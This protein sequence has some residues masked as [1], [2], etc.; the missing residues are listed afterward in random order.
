[1]SGPIPK[2]DPLWLWMR[3]AEKKRHAGAYLGYVGY[4]AL[5]AAT[6]QEVSA[7]KA[8]E[9]I[10]A[11]RDTVR[12]L[13]GQF[14]TLG[15]VYRSGWVRESTNGFDQPLYRIRVEDEQ[16]VPARLT[17]AGGPMP[18]ADHEH[19]PQER[20]RSFAS[21]VEALKN[22]CLSR[23]ELA[24]KTGLSAARI[25]KVLSYMASP[26]VKLIYVADWRWRGGKPG[27]PPSKLWEFGLDKRNAFRPKPIGRGRRDCKR[28][29][30]TLGS[31]PTWERT[32]AMLR[33]TAGFH[34][35]FSASVTKPRTKKEIPCP[36]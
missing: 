16:D 13:L 26:G 22:D 25:T 29:V 11:H 4:A 5:L 30:E 28:A 7:T 9:I 8:A 1:M 17:S 21:L 18:H 3:G 14:R 36:P 15:L 23:G 31:A 6:K 27:G 24:E 34:V 32:L 12:R 19:K 33:T 20:V 10:G 35:G 2:D